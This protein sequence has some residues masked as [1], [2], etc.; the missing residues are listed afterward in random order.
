M[1]SLEVLAL[2]Q[3]KIRQKLVDFF[4]HMVTSNADRAL[5]VLNYLEIKNWSDLSPCFADVDN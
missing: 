4:S 3:T 2:F 5:S 1:G